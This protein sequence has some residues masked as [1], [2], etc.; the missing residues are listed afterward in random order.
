M[1]K[2]NTGSDASSLDHTALAAA[3]NRF[4][5]QLLKLLLQCAGEL[6]LQIYLVGG[7][8]RDALTGADTRDIDLA[9]AGGAQRF[10]GRVRRHLGYG[11]LVPLG[12]PQDDTCRLVIDELAID[13]AG[14]RGESATIEEDL[15]RRDFTINAMALRLAEAL[16]AGKMPELIDPLAGLADL[17][18][19]LI[20]ACTGAFSDDPLRLLR[21]YRFAAQLDFRIEEKTR[22]EINSGSAWI[23]RCAA[24]RISYELDL[25]MGT[26]RAFAAFDAMRATGLLMHLVPELYDGAGIEQ[27]PFHHLDVMDHNLKTLDWLE[28]I[29]AGPDSY[30]PGSGEALEKSGGAP[31]QYLELK[32]AALFHDVGKPATRQVSSEKQGR[33]TFYRHDE[34]GAAMARCIGERL[35]WSRSRSRRISSLIEMHMHPFHLGNV[36]GTEGSL[37]SRAMLKLCRRAGDQLIPLFFLAMAD[38][39]AGQGAD[40]PEHLETLLQ[41]LFVDLTH[42][43]AERMQP[44][45]SGPKLLTGHDLIDTLKL[46]PGPEIGRLL[47]AVEAAAVAGEI[48]SKQEALDW[49]Q[50]HLEYR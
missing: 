17:E 41:Q 27:P 44:V 4:P 33:I 1:T 9:I 37:S 46:E 47:E 22:E 34:R 11:A 35:R 32:W 23:S 43:Y 12:E 2:T 13:V 20:R 3:L 29:I 48:G 5:E 18:K 45:L 30:F 38:S 50:K 10:L 8:L 24:E 14:Y 16:D 39:L 36:L 28:H 49:L 42:F 21:A 19:G 6:E 15:A 7:V 25:I 26:P 40:K 31:E